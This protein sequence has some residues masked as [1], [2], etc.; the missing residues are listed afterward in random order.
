VI[1]RNG[2]QE[3]TRTPDLCGVNHCQGPAQTLGNKRKARFRWIEERIK[4]V[5]K[6]GNGVIGS[7]N[8]CSALYVFWGLLLGDLRAATS[9]SI[10]LT[11]TP[12]CSKNHRQFISSASQR[13]GPEVFLW[14]VSPDK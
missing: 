5:D 1:E 6:P 7:W 11:S 10:R 9:R 4:A 13:H 8:Y 2:R 12:T 3:E 14:E